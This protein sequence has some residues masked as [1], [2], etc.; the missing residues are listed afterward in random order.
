MGASAATSGTSL[1]SV[2]NSAL[3]VSGNDEYLS[4]TPGATGVEEKGTFSGWLYRGKMTADSFYIFTAYVSGTQFFQLYFTSAG[5]LNCS[6]YSGGYDWNL[7]ASQF[8]RDIGW[9]HI[10]LGVD[11]TQAEASERAILYVNG[12]RVTA[13]DTETYPSLN[14]VNDFNTS[15]VPNL[16]GSFDTTPTAEYDG[17]IA[18]L[19]WIDGTQYAASDFGEFDSSGLFWTPKS[20]ASIKELTFGTNGF[21]LDNTTNAQTDASGEGNNFTNN[22]TVTLSTHTPTN[23]SS[24]LNHLYATNGNVA[25]SNGNRT[26]AANGAVNEMTCATLA[27]PPNSGKWYFDVSWDTWADAYDDGYIGI[28]LGS[29]IRAGMSNP[30]SESNTWNIYMTDPIKII[31]GD[32]SAINTTQAF[33]Q[34]G[35]IFQVAY[36]SDTGKLFLGY[37][38]ASATAEKWFSGDGTATAG[39][40]SAGSNP[41]VTLSVADRALPLFPFAGIGGNSGQKFTVNFEEDE[42]AR[43]APTGFKALTTTNL[44]AQTTRTASDTTKYFDT[45]LYEGNGGGQRVGQF[46]PFDNAFTVA[47]GGLF[48]LVATT[49]DTNNAWLTRSQ[50]AGASQKKFTFSFWFKMSDISLGTN[51]Y[52]WNDD[53]A[54]YSGILFT[55]DEKLQLTSYLGATQMDVATNRV[56]HDSSQWYHAVIAVDTAQSEALERVR[57]YIN[58]VEEAVTVT[59]QVPQDSTL[60]SV[61]DANDISV[62]AFIASS[63]PRLPYDGYLAEFVYINNVQLTPSSFGQ[64]D[65]ST[66][67]WI[68]KAVSGLTYDATGYYLNFAGA[69]SDLGDDAS[70]NSNDFT[71]NNNNA[72]RVT[73]SPTTNYAVF[74]INNSY[75]SYV[76]LTNG[77]RTATNSS[78]YTAVPLNMSFNMGAGNSKIWYMEFVIDSKNSNQ[79]QFPLF[80]VAP[81]DHNFRAVNSYAGSSADSISYRADGTKIISGATSAYGATFVV[82][83]VIGMLITESTGTVTMYKQTSGSGSFASQ[84]EL[85]TGLSGEY[86]V[87]TLP[88]DDTSST[89][90]SAKFTCRI[91]SADWG[92]ASPP[93]DAEALSQDNL[94]STDQFISAFSWI[95]NRDATDNHM[96]FDRVRGVT[97][98]MHSNSATAEVTNL[99]TVQRFLANGVQVGND[100]EVNT[101]NESYALWNWMMETTGGGSSNTAGSINTEATLVDTTLGLSISKF[102][103]GSAGD[104]TIGHGLG[105]APEFIIF[106]DLE[107]ANNWGVYHSG[108]GFADTQDYL[109]LNSDAAKGDNGANMWGSAFP[110]STV[111]GFTSGQICN[112]D[113]DCIAYC[114]APSQF[115]SIGAYVGNGN[116]DGALVPTINSVGIPIQPVFLLYKDIGNTNAWC[117]VDTKR[118]PFNVGDD[119]LFPAGTDVEQTNSINNLDIVTGGLK[120]RT[121]YNRSNGSS[122]NYIYIVIGTP[123]IDTDGRIIAGK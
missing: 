59:N 50:D 107:S 70:G 67:R 73:D 17:Y 13:F 81:I 14:F 105:V 104:H 28:A 103:S 56:F 76:T 114:F 26:I 69:T 48:N 96:L 119:V 63:A 120:F 84:G 88:I 18:E 83:D 53:A 46:Q 29:L 90:G 101:A 39:D 110:T 3:Y 111:F 52:L 36:D 11:T 117:I 100:V 1:V 54:A 27:I 55:S 65:T 45:I 47:Y 9:Y 98:D 91:D 77:N 86:L 10:V 108:A 35:D 24:L 64:T 113:K 22:N 8:F 30:T 79:A 109:L 44:A 5:K 61:G 87:G 71:N 4:R 80:G 82:S 12:K 75:A 94:P 43:T 116:V 40:P 20:S 25:Y 102:D 66:N 122:Y 60:M 121:T 37:Y 33:N 89:T 58:G 68:P 112:V 74:D 38:D 2:G 62:G 57:I 92:N 95:K 51:H 85:I 23:S 19:V 99:E 34:I 106:K 32:G 21:Y 123:I 15:S 42:F 41:T 97:K 31:L 16:I 49:Q 118:S 72:L 115:I 6:H 78:S 7:S 93:T